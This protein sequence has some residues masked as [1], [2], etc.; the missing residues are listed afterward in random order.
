M[1]PDCIY[2]PYA[3]S[4]IFVVIYYILL[5]F[6]FFFSKRIKIP[7]VRIALLLLL[8]ASYGNQH[9][10]SDCYSKGTL[11]YFPHFLVKS[12]AILN[13]KGIFPYITQLDNN[14]PGDSSPDWTDGKSHALVSLTLNTVSHA[15]QY[16]STRMSSLKGVK[17]FF[18]W[19]VSV[20]LSPDNRLLLCRRR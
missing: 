6:F 11:Y 7:V 2:S 18:I 1:W 3:Y 13:S 17:N 16:G 15:G 5:L 9:L 8:I 19:E 12:V 4:Y 14:N 10:L 20:C